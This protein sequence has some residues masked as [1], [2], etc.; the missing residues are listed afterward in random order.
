[1]SIEPQSLNI[2]LERKNRWGMVLPF[3]GVIAVG[4][5]AIFDTEFAIVFAA[6]C[7]VGLPVFWL[8]LFPPFYIAT[9]LQRRNFGTVGSY[10]LMFSYLALS[11]K[12]LVPAVAEFITKIL[13]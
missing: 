5:S 11:K 12:V 6:A 8:L 9:F 3:A 13:L 1:M 4:I 7:I 2:P 10:L